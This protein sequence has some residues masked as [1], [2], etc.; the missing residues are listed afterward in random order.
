MLTPAMK[1][2]RRWQWTLAAG[3]G[4]ALVSPAITLLLHTGR[5][6]RALIARLES[7]FGRQVSVGSFDWN[8]LG[9]PRLGA[10]YVTVEEDPRFGAEYFLRGERVTAG[11]RWKSLLSGRLEFGAIRLERHSL[12]V[13]RGPGGEWNV[14]SW[15]RP[16]R[17]PPGAGSAVA[18]GGGAPRVEHI[19]LENCRVNL[20]QSADK[21]PLAFAGVTGSLD[22]ESD[23]SW[24][25]ELEARP[26]R[27]GVIVQDTG[28]IEVSGRIGG[29]EAA[30]GAADLRIQWRDA[31]LS[32]ALRLVR[33]HD[34]GMRGRFSLE[35]GARHEAPA[36]TTVHPWEI[37]AALRLHDIH[38]WDLAPRAGDPALN[39][40]AAGRWWP[41]ESRVEITRGTLEGPRSSVR[42]TG[43]AGWSGNAGQDS[44]LVRARVVSTGIELD[45]GVAWLRAFRLGVSDQLRAEGNAGLDVH[46]TGWPL[47]IEKGVLASDAAD[48]RTSRGGDT[49][50]T[51]RVVVKIE[52]ARA[53]LRPVEIFLRSETEG[54]IQNNAGKPGLTLRGKMELTGPWAWELLLDGQAAQIT[55]LLGAA[56]TAGWEPVPGWR[57]DSAGRIQ[58]K[59]AGA[60]RTG[61][62]ISPR[63]AKL[64]QAASH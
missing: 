19:R 33:E 44:A 39:L 13:V 57:A 47:R 41:E 34:Y 26:M 55:E 45:D 54:A 30:R 42:V 10:N 9:G 16:G 48:I 12:N 43:T 25:L 59:A 7:S 31:S 28:T 63:R 22:R 5:A 32:D 29:K 15:Y 56:K 6:R 50:R 3:A 35:L 4:L 20:K 14:D 52:R 2:R 51:G 8:I 27:A 24:R 36:K 1:R 38:R 18:G 60:G 17:V 21:L 23:G 49:L 37:T 11:L 62:V 58:L 46:I 61:Q 40:L 64:G 53:T